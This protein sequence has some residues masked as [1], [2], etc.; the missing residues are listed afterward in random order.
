MSSSHLICTHSSGLLAAPAWI[1]LGCIWFKLFRCS[2]KLS[3]VSE[4]LSEG[5]EPVGKAEYWVKG[6]HDIIKHPL[7]HAQSSLVVLYPA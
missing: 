2:T 7:G 3:Y 4:E 5:K 6:W 1:L